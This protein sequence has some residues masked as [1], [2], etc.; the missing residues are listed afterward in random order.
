MPLDFAGSSPTT[1]LTDVAQ[2]LGIKP[3]P[4]SELELHKVAELRKNPGSMFY[5]VRGFVPFLLLIG[6]FSIVV[7][8]NEPSS[9]LGNGVLHPFLSA[10]VFMLVSAVLVF[11]SKVRLKAPAK[12]DERP[13]IHQIDVPSSIASMARMVTEFVPEAIVVVG[14]L[15]QE[16]VVL[17][18][19]LVIRLNDQQICLGIWDDQGVI[20]EAGR[21]E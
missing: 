7:L 10:V 19:Y 4:N 20:K 6:S 11:G 3:I 9:S 14:E 18:P 1:S 17:D 16:S 15:K 12:W 5:P 2:W 13:G 8:I 21:A